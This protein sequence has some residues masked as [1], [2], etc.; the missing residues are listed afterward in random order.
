VYFGPPAETVGSAEMEQA[1]DYAAFGRALRQLRRNCALTLQEVAQASRNSTAGEAGYISRAYLS[2]IEGGGRHA[3]AYAKV[4]ALARIYGVAVAHIIDLAPPA[5]RARLM[6]EHIASTLRDADEAT[7]RLPRPALPL[8]IEVDQGLY[9]LIVARAQQVNVPID[10]EEYLRPQILFLIQS[11]CL[12]IWL[13]A[14]GKALASS[15]AES[16]TEVLA[17]PERWGPMPSLFWWDRLLRSFADYV[18]YE[19][20]LAAEVIEPLVSWHADFEAWSASCRFQPSLVNRRFGFSGIPVAVVRATRD[21]QSQAVLA[22]A[23]ASRLPSVAPPDPPVYAGARA[24][25][26]LSLYAHDARV[27][28][29][30]PA[31]LAAAL[32]D[33]NELVRHIP[34]LQPPKGRAG[35]ALIKRV[36]RFLH[37]APTGGEGL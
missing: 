19:R 14:N 37:S 31:P 17:E 4:V 10:K 8:R 20:A 34:E 13:G 24:Y 25:L 12:P 21:A 30:E 1:A 16:H 29:R 11:A 6:R 26:E 33:A 27:G 3:I 9:R 22:D 18:L 5:A 36:A 35:S 7:G 2:Q 23:L 15:F 32:A 28:P